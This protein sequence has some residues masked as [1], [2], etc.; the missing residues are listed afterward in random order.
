[1]TTCYFQNLRVLHVENELLNLFIKSFMGIINKFEIRTTNYRQKKVREK[2]VEFPDFYRFS[3][4]AQPPP[5][6]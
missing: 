6:Q 2:Y 4:L 3:L 1:M 5:P